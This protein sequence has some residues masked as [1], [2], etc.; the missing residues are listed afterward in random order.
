MGLPG[1]R[2]GQ[3]DTK[4]RAE[5]KKSVDILENGNAQGARNNQSMFKSSR[6][7]KEKAAQFIK[8]NIEKFT[9]DYAEIEDPKERCD[10][11]IKMMGYVVPK[12]SSTDINASL[13]V[14]S[15]GDELAKLARTV[16]T[17][18]D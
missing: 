3:K 11:F 13:E 5:Y 10:I 4:P 15:V 14:E 12:M 16:P 18:T 2:L 6:E 1:R 7:A 9:R 17:A 8:D